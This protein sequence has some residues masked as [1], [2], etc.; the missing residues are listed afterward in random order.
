MQNSCPPDV[1]LI[2]NNVAL[3]VAAIELNRQGRNVVVLLDGKRPGAHFAG[4][5]IEGSQFDIGMVFFERVVR[6]PQSAQATDYDP[7]RRNDCAR[8]AQLIQEFLE[9]RV[10]TIQVATPNVYID[11]HRYPDFVIANRLDYFASSDCRPA[12]TEALK[13]LPEPGALHAANRQSSDYDGLS[14]R[15]ASLANH[16]EP[17]HHLFELLASKIVAQSTDGMFARYHRLAWLPL[18]YPETLQ[19]ALAGQ[20]DSLPEY[21]FWAAQDGFFGVLVQQLVGELE[22]AGV[23][24]LSSQ[25]QQM[26]RKR[27]GV[28]VT[29]ADGRHFCA[30]RVGLGVALGRAGE[31]LGV[32]EPAPAGASVRVLFGLIARE[33]LCH[34]DSCLLVLDPACAIYRLTNQD[35][36]AA[37]GA[38]ECRVTVELSP[39]Y[40]ASLYPDSDDATLLERVRAEL[41]KLEV[42]R[43]PADFRL[44]R[45]VEAQSALPIANDAL[46]RHTSK[47]AE[48]AAGW[49]E[50]ALTAGLLGV[51][52][53]SFN[54]QIIQGLKLAECWSVA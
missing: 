33:A 28:E 52:V 26:E 20:L 2:G 34:A 41:V 19:R 25:V 24:L 23:E 40:C 27:D 8:F 4:M 43:A 12:I 14:Y 53:S 50:L 44:L 32:D 38:A 48:A 16:G 49:P 39:T 37:T 54:D 17:L 21:P 5:Q 15:I 10:A 13:A 42:I 51:G 46:V 35:Q 22:T 31:L 18:Y 6:G 1:L 36:A 45:S 7:G 11:G 29:C 3:L 47:V 9:P 30:P